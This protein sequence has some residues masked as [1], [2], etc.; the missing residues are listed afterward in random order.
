MPRNEYATREMDNTDCA[1]MYPDCPCCTCIN[2]SR[3]SKYNVPRCC[4]YKDC[5]S[6]S[7]GRYVPATVGVM[8][9]FMVEE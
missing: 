9:E 8:P 2:W 5:R 3:C 7:C 4:R 6:S 1:V